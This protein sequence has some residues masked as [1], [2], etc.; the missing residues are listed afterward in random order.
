LRPVSKVRTAIQR[1]EYCNKD[2][3]EFA[4]PVR[5]YRDHRGDR[6]TGGDSCAV[7]NQLHNAVHISSAKYTFAAF[8][9]ADGTVVA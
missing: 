1:S 8:R 3:A 5:R 7:T 2:D 4:R 9:A 6:C